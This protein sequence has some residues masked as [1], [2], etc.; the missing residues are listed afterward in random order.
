MEGSDE[1]LELDEGAPNAER[2]SRTLW[3]YG[4]WAGTVVVLRAC[5]APASKLPET[6]VVGQDK[7]LHAAGFFFLAYAWR[8]TGMT[9]RNVLILCAFLAIGTE[10]GQHLLGNGRSADAW[11]VVADMIGA[12]AAMLVM[13]RWPRL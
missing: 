13:A 8:K 3:L 9:I 2:K 12:A 11:D 10:I 4:A 1:D 7:L 5:F 6:T